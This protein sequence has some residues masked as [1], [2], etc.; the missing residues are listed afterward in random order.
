MPRDGSIELKKVA[1]NVVYSMTPVGLEQLKQ[2]AQVGTPKKDMA[3]FFGVSED[4]LSAAI[5]SDP[6]V[7][8]AYEQGE[9]DGKLELRQAL[10]TNALAGDSRVLTFLGERRLGMNK[11]VEHVHD[12]TH[13]V[14]GAVPNYKLSPVEWAE[15]FA[16]K[17]LAAPATEVTATAPATPAQQPVDAEFEPVP[18]KKSPQEA[19]SARPNPRHRDHGQD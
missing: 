5:I 14:I 13:R 4:W 18:A 19:A 9:G 1:S 3:E 11:T 8:T 12:H 10:H 15:Q 2:L 16:P 6:Y 17:Q 7:R